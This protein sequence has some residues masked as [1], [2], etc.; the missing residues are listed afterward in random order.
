MNSKIVF[1]KNLQIYLMNADGTQQTQVTSGGVGT[2]TKPML[3][4][5]GSRIAYFDGGV[6][7]ALKIINAD[8]SGEKEIL[9]SAFGLAFMGAVDFSWSPDGSHLLVNIQR[10]INFNFEYSL[11]KIGVDGF[12][13]I[14]LITSQDMS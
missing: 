2:K 1:V 6:G 4:P 7:N 5:D 11:W 8:G 14:K 12:S 13:R 9:P 3:S 10:I